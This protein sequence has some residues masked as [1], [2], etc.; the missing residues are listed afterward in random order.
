MGDAVEIATDVAEAL[1][2]AHEQG[3]IHRDIKPSNILISRGKPLI[4]DFGIALAISTA[5]GGERLTET[6]LSLGT[7]FYI[8]GTP[9]LDVYW[10]MNSV[11]L[12]G[13]KTGLLKFGPP[14]RLSF[15][16]SNAP[17]RIVRLSAGENA[18]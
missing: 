16:P 4:A 7:P 10:R 14:L 2:A 15:I 9:L 8:E 1:Q 11:K 12:T 13:S 6:G 5:G 17:P 3:V 18:A